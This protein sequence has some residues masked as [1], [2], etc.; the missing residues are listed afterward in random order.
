MSGWGDFPLQKWLSDQ[1]GGAAVN[2]CND[3]NAAALAE[4]REG[5]GQD[6]SPVFYI[7]LGSGIGGGLIVD[8][9]LYNGALPTEMEIGHVIINDSG[10]TLESRCSGWSVD[11]RLQNY[12]ENNSDSCLARMVKG[13]GG[14]AM[15]LLS[16]INEDDEGARYIFDE[17]CRD[18]AIGL[19]HV[20]HLLNPAVIVLGG[21]L[22]LMGEPLRLGVEQ[23]LQQTIMNVI[24]P[25]PN[26][27]LAKLRED[28]V[29]I[30]A[31]HLALMT[32]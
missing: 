17:V 28:A 10:E 21:G 2:I 19:S 13:R 14:E 27:R 3:A 16:A 31:L 26:I 1:I 23:A 6:E 5:A 32:K 22:S 8:G 25:G 4:A 15:H 7:T 29:P 20:V 18:L 24:K 9:H 11:K 12:I 30:G